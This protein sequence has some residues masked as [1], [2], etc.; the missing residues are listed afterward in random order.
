MCE[1]SLVGRRKARICLVDAQPIK[2]KAKQDKSSQTAAIN[3]K[4]DTM[5]P[6][7]ISSSSK[8]A[9]VIMQQIIHPEEQ[10]R[11]EDDD[12]E[13]QPIQTPP[14]APPTVEDPR[15]VKMNHALA[16][17]NASLNAL[18]M[19]VQNDDS[20]V[21]KIKKTAPMALQL[22]QQVEK[23]FDPKNP[24]V[25]E[26]TFG[27]L[28]NIIQK[29]AAEV[30][31]QDD[32]A[33]IHTLLTNLDKSLYAVAYGF[34]SL[35]PSTASNHVPNAMHGENDASTAKSP[36]AGTSSDLAGVDSAINGGQ[37]A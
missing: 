17:V 25:S 13:D 28:V 22:L 19:G 4:R 8:D 3:A 20:I 30:V 37:E 36:P 26:K 15:I 6:S 33:E 29:M 14:A 21:D 2:N 34:Q 16:G 35:S 31:E 23:E 27:Q 1:F 12:P 11:K 9:G 18:M 32:D 24:S 10:S 5:S 7:H